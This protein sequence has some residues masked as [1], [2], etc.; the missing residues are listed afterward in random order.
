MVCDDR[1]VPDERASTAVPD[2]L[3]AGWRAIM[4]WSD[5]GDRA[6]S[7]LAGRY[8]EPHRRYHGVEHL[9]HVVRR[10]DDLLEGDV[11]VIP[12][13]AENA[14]LLAAWFHDAVYDPRADDNERRSADLAAQVLSSLGA[15]APLIA[16]V[17]RLV[18]ATRNHRP[19]GLDEA[20]LLDADLAILGAPPDIYDDYVRS[21]H[22]E[23]AHVSD[24]D[25][26]I[27]RAQVLR[28]LL[29]APIFATNAAAVANAQAE[30]NLTR[31]LSDL[32]G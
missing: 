9:V 25:W 30:A 11:G 31:E 2:D 19:A 12:P 27:G 18:M 8:A 32:N 5:A 13:D 10:V 22:G 21:V 17:E 6:M 20:V 1:T 3:V 16:A 24:A 7:E 14:I 23:Y 28:H 29:A 4:G 26:R 15:P